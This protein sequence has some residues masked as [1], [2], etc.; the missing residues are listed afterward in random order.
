VSRLLACSL[1]MSLYGGVQ[2]KCVLLVSSLAL[3]LALSLGKE[4]L[5]KLTIPPAKSI[6]KTEPRAAKIGT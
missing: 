5:S 3:S 6:Q 1:Q 4:M 2:R